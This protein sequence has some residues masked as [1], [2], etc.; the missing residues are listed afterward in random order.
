MANKWRRS[1]VN[2]VLLSHYAILTF[3]TKANAL[4]GQVGNR[5]SS[6]VCKAM[7]AHMV[8]KGYKKLAVGESSPC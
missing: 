2:H 3:S 7:L 4:S 8:Y 6:M 1:E 5:I